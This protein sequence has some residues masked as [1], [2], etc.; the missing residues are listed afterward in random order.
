MWKKTLK[1]FDY[2]VST[3]LRRTYKVLFRTKAGGV[4]VQSFGVRSF[5]CLLF[6]YMI[7]IEDLKSSG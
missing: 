3:V 4:F 7:F 2:S 1:Q 5:L 6:Q